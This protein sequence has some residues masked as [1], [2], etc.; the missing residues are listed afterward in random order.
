MRHGKPLL[1]GSIA[2]HL[3]K[4]IFGLYFV[5]TVIVTVIQLSVEYND[6]K[7]N[8]RME[9]ES[10]G[11]T[12]Q[13]GLEEAIWSYNM[14]LLKSILKG[15]NQVG[16]ITGIKIVDEVGNE[17]QLL[18]TIK[19]KDGE[20]YLVNDSGERL[21]LSEDEGIFTGLFWYEFPII[22]RASNGDSTP[23][24]TGVIYS[25]DII[26]F[27]RVEY[28]FILILVNSIIK[29]VA[30]WIIFLFFVRR[31]LAEPLGKLTED[32]KK[33]RFDNPDQKKIVVDT[34]GANELKILEQSF[35][36]MIDRNI[37]LL[38]D[39]REREQ[40]QR[41]KEIAEAASRAKSQFLA[42][43][44]HE[45]RTP[46]NAI[47]GLSGLALRTSLTDKQSDYL[48]KIDTSANSLLRIINDIL[49]YSKI[50]A[51]KMTIES[52]RF[53]LN[54]VL[55]NVS[56]L[57]T[58]KCEEKGLEFIFN[59]APKVPQ[60]LVGDPL[61]LGQV[62]INLASNAVK[63]TEKGHVLIHVEA[64]NDEAVNGKADDSNRIRLK[65]SVEDTGIGL[66][67]EQI[68]RLFQSFTQADDSITR[69]FGGT[70]LGLTIC[71]DLVELMGGDIS[72]VSQV[73]SGS[74]FFFTAEFSLHTAEDF[75][76]SETIGDLA[77]VRVL[78]V[79][80]HSTARQI[81][82]DNLISFSA[83]VDEAKSGAEAVDMVE[84]MSSDDP[85]Q[86]ILMDWKMP[87]MDGIEASNR[88]RRITTVE[89][90]PSILMVTAFGREEV[91]EKANTAGV[92]GFL[93]KPITRSL[94]LNTVRDICVVSS[95]IPERPFEE[96][97]P[98]RCGR[99]AGM[100][101]LLAEDN[102]IN[103]Q[104]VIELLEYENCSVVVANNGQE[105]LDIINASD[106]LQF[107][108]ILMDL[109][110]P[111]MDG[112]TATAAIRDLGGDFDKIPIIAMTAHVLES[113]KEDC[114]SKGMNDH[115]SKP[116]VPE[117]LYATLDKW[118]RPMSTAGRGFAKREQ[119]SIVAI[120]NSLAGINVAEG[121]SKVAGNSSAFKKVLTSFRRHNSDFDFRLRQSITDG[122]LEER[123]RLLHTIKGV[124]G[125]IGAEKLHLLAA[126]LESALKNPGMEPP[127]DLV[128]T[129]CEE[130]VLVLNSIEEFEEKEKEKE[131]EKSVS[132]ERKVATEDVSEDSDKARALVAQ[133]ADL[134]EVDVIATRKCL[135]QLSC[136]LENSTEFDA[137]IA[138]FEDYDTDAAFEALDR[139]TI[140]LEG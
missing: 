25:S 37:G 133:V 44:S 1:N 9:I 101:V 20:G 6:T 135:T 103:Q 48:Q 18:G 118:F 28:G 105:A 35:N 122:E 99:F 39:L 7:N 100:K 123:K 8:V 36:A 22:H 117:L 110:M 50:E 106:N 38:Q 21:L 111:I 98:L 4:V 95:S 113:E 90:M 54:E 104:V 116:V 5:V 125:N 140:S 73:D 34:K 12:F 80:D 139:L 83:R 128:E 24:G 60:S 132:P 130:L 27:D 69:R 82:K 114:L 61:R 72:V 59:T 10:L 115:V 65:F 77:G 47:I 88:I 43:M 15:M 107:D 56:N 3:L 84:N 102:E 138:A 40:A 67:Q 124:S 51:G 53:E 64:V 96:P 55:E 85:Y 109:Q 2:T 17:I 136:L 79:D 26:V 46:M 134:L 76:T 112:Y 14:P 29:T 94:L 78:V 42:A 97:E 91:K 33:I 89:K 71:K 49:D 41:D 74:T 108:L 58:S 32:I 57:I 70:G 127:L 75:V 92:D 16:T 62:L 126:E 137:L 31:I 68:G 81:L 19:D 120:P 87:G 63:F 52:T 93:I 86:L 30:L 131:K 23:I 129:F 45:I 121:L 66:T 11:R 13:P 119:A